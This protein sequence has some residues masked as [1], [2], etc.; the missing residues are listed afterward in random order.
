VHTDTAM[1]N[2]ASSGWEPMPPSYSFPDIDINLGCFDFENFDFEDPNWDFEEWEREFNKA[3]ESN[4]S[5][6]APSPSA[7]E[8]HPQI[9]CP[10]N[11]LLPSSSFPSVIPQNQTYF[12]ESPQIS[13]T[14]YA[15]AAK[16]TQGTQEVIQ[17]LQQSNQEL[18]QRNQELQ[19]RNQE[20]QQRNQELQQRIAELEMEVVGTG[21]EPE[22]MTM[23]ENG[24]AT[25]LSNTLDIPF[26]EKV[27]ENAKPGSEQMIISENDY[28]TKLSNTLDISSKKKEPKNARSGNIASFKPEKFY[29]PLPEWE[30]SWSSPSGFT[31]HY[32][33]EGELDPQ[34][35]FDAKEILDY[36]ENHA[37]HG[38]IKPGPRTNSGSGLTLWVQNNPAD[39]GIRYP[40]VLSSKCRFAN[41]PVPNNTISKGEFRVAFDELDWH[42]QAQKFDPFH[43]AGYVH[44]Y[45]LELN[46]DF[47][48]LCKKYNVIGDRREFPLERNKMAITRDY[49]SMWDIVDNFIKSSRPWNGVRPENWYDESLCLLLTREHLAK[50]PKQRQGVREARNG[51]SIDRHL[52]NLHVKMERAQA[53]KVSK[54]RIKNKEGAQPL[55]VQLPKTKRKRKTEVEEDEFEID[56]A[57]LSEDQDRLIKR[58]RRD[59]KLSR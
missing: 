28:A 20:L 32:T 46:L 3:Y 1:E 40:T 50:Q 29:I 15:D 17:E 2:T 4:H 42:E 53:I 45:C 36:L 8:L 21:S 23:P 51:N 12:N 30:Q 18:Q 19:E 52:N 24:S 57:I 39:A 38:I 13:P 16:K 48:S 25:N 34:I 9:A 49:S 31:F 41:C 5:P 7:S 27:R 55:K 35:N 33:T 54:A 59:L 14:S 10:E 6:P 47:P 37:L 44:L 11:L 26:N 43:N 58:S 22:Q 56:P